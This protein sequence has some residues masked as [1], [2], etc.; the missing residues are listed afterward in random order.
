MLLATI[1]TLKSS[2]KVPNI[3]VPFQPNLDYLN[4]FSQKLPMSNL[5]KT[6]P[7]GAML[8]HRARR[9]DMMNPICASGD[10]VNA[11]NKGA[12]ERLTN[13][14][15]PAIFGFTVHTAAFCPPTP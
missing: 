10:Y 2:H 13:H 8:I 12:S 6:H 11:L 4:S 7:M 3:F 14:M 15:Q 9:T 5:M 1:Q